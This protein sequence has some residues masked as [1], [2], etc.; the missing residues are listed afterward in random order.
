M[1]MIYFSPVPWRSYEQRPHFFV[2]NYL[3]QGLDRVIWV[4]PYPHRLPRLSD[5]WRLTNQASPG[6]SP[7]GLF[8][9]I[10]P[11]GTKALPLEPFAFG[12]FL[13]RHLLLATPR[14][15]MQEAVSQDP[16]TV[17]VV[18]KPSSLA[19]DLVHAHPELPVVY[20][21][22]DDFPRFSTGKASIFMQLTEQR[23]AASADT[24]TVSSHGLKKK[25]EN[26]GYQPQLILNAAAEEEFPA[27][28]T[29]KP[30]GKT[31]GYVG[32]IGIWFDWARVIRLARTRPDYMIR[33]IGPQLKPPPLGLPGNIRLE[34]ELPHRQ[35][36]AAMSTFDAGLIPFLVDDLTESI[37]PVKYYDY[38]FMGLSVLSTRFGEMKLRTSSD[39]VF[40]LDEDLLQP[41][42]DALMGRP[43]TAET[44]QLSRFEQLVIPLSPVRTE[45]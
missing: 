30:R 2:A 20:D 10:E 40:F 4:E 36:I 38:R 34:G 27:R 14:R 11:L 39:H 44:M 22:M 24:L 33:L 45:P 15:K 9:Q 3:S 41:L 23:I 5:L 7:A 19:A 43:S 8:C 25:F 35:A 29:D 1:Q 18:G 13:N 12:R 26:L 17:I 42:D 28:A 32:A 21:A 37:D 6:E 16:E 31:L